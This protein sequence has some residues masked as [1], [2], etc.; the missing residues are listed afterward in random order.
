M[1]TWEKPKLI[2]LVRG[3]PEEAILTN[4]KTIT[5]TMGPWVFYEG[6]Y[7]Y[8]EEDEHMCMPSTCAGLFG[9]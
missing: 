7:N 9:S 2:V 1:K 3:T 8:W 6:C 5:T 4:C